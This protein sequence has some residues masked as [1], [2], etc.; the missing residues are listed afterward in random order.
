[1]TET[2]IL[3]DRAA[4]IGSSRKPPGRKTRPQPGDA[5]YG[6]SSITN[7]KRLH[8]PASAGD[9]T[10]SRRFKDIYSPIGRRH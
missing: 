4:E 2:A 7:G 9:A 3:E 10:W 1:M 8:I 5:R 6:Q